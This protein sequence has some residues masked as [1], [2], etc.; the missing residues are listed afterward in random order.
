M[1]TVLI[2]NAHPYLHVHEAFRLE[3]IDVWAR[4]FGFHVIGRVTRGNTFDYS[5]LGLTNTTFTT[6][7]QDDETLTQEFTELLRPH[8][9]RRVVNNLEIFVPWDLVHTDAEKMYFF[10]SCAAKLLKVMQDQNDSSEHA[11]TAIADYAAY[12]QREQRFVMMSDTFITDSPN[13]IKA[14]KEMYHYVDD[15]KLGLE[16]VN[17][18]KYLQV[19]IAT[20]RSSAVYTV[21]RVDYQKGLQN[22][23]PSDRYDVLVIGLAEVHGRDFLEGR[24]TRLG[25][26]PFEQYREKIAHCQFGM[27]PSIW[28]SNGYAVQECLAMGKIPIIQAGSGGNE[29]L[30]RHMENGLV[31]DFRTEHWQTYIDQLTDAEIVRMQ[32]AGKQ[33][34]TQ[35]MFR[36]S[37]EK[38]AEQIV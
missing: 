32:N 24:F 25:M 27:F 5:T 3:S 1:T 19:P 4:E 36:D 22:I 20:T 12:V 29:R 35:K 33:T 11:Q 23:K 37:L 26:L 28:E 8:Q 18:D 9:P 6:P 10:R 38:W 13:S 15:I 31:I 30:V 7:H 21:G 34:L 16:F 17:P 2:T 14:I